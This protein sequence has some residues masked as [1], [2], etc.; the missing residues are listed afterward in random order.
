MWA[1]CDVRSNIALLSLSN[2]NHHLRSNIHE[3]S[4]WSPEALAF[5]FRNLCIPV[6]PFVHLLLQL[7]TSPPSCPINRSDLLRSRNE[8][9]AMARIKQQTARKSPSKAH[10]PSAEV[11]RAAKAKA[12]QRSKPTSEPVKKRKKTRPRQRY[13]PP[14]RPPGSRRRYSPGQHALRDIKH[15]Q[16]S[17]HMLMPRLPFQRL[18]REVAEEMKEGR[19]I[20]LRFQSSAVMALQVSRRLLAS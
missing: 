19:F 10:Q 11:L 18:V 3:D 7:A 1:V 17:F 4:L 8:E 13:K 12:G 6:A 15:Y 16:N 5:L 20:Q 2:K 14:S 9:K